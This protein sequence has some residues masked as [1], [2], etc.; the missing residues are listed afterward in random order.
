MQKLAGTRHREADP[1]VK[2]SNCM[3][4]G[5]QNLEDESDRQGDIVNMIVLS[6]DSIRSSVI[7]KVGTY[8]RQRA[9]NE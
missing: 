7:A 3:L 8:K 6:F 4:T 2:W 5:W 1:D 9:K